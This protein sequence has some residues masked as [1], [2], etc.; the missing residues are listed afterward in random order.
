MLIRGVCACVH[1]IHLRL[2]YHSQKKKINSWLKTVFIG[3][4]VDAFVLKNNQMVENYIVMY[5]SLKGYA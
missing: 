2:Y 4:N 1:S 5:A 3:V